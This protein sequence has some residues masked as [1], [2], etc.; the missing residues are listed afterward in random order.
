VYFGWVHVDGLLSYIGALPTALL[1]TAAA[2][3]ELVTDKLPST[4]SRTAPMGLAVRVVTGALTGA[5]IGASTSGALLGAVLGIVGS[6]AGCF[7]GYAARTRLV[8][9]LGVPDF[10]VA[11]AEDLVAVAGCLWVVSQ[12]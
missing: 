3:G 10:V 1:L 2:I 5:C 9:S 8:Q 7:A 6:L 11:F 12:F 4:P